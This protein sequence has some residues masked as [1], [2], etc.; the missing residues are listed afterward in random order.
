MS[1]NPWKQ[2]SGHFA[3]V[4]GS[5][6]LFGLLLGAQRP[7]TGQ[8][9]RVRVEL[10]DV[11]CGNTEDVTGPDEFYLVGAFEQGGKAKSVLTRPFD[12][13]DG[14]TQTFPASEKVVFDGDVPLKQSISGGLIAYD[15]DYAKDWA[16]QKEMAK[17]ITDGV[18]AGASSADNKNVRTAGTVLK[19]AYEI[20]NVIASLDQDDEL[21][22]T[23][24]NVAA[25]GPAEETI[26][27]KFERK[28]PTG[29]S[30]WEYT[31]RYRITRTR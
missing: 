27:W 22:R 10:L 8:T 20:W 19:I 11:Q 21:G 5:L 29:F 15:E 9:V 26:A 3:V 7:V 30:S 16:K 31:V 6:V 1:L 2:D 4:T 17:K 14:Q 13:N 18:S 24:I 12:I 28:D 23:E 25:A